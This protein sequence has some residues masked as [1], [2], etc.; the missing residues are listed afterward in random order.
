M[1]LRMTVATL[2]LLAIVGCQSAAP[3]IEPPI[4]F[5]QLAANVTPAENGF[6][7]LES[8][9]S[10]GR[11]ATTLAVAKFA[12]A[13]NT[14]ATLSLRNLPDAEQAYWADTFRG[15]KPV[16]DLVFLSPVTFPSSAVTL[17]EL[18]NEARSLGATVLLTYAPN[19]YGPNA[20]QVLGVL[21][22]TRSG[23]AIATLHAANVFLDSAGDETAVDALR[24]DQREQDAAYQS[25]RRFEAYARSCINNLIRLDRPLDSA[26]AA[27]TLHGQPLPIIPLDKP[28][29]SSA[30]K[31]PSEEPDSA[32]AATSEPEFPAPLPN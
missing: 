19:R 29:A 20:A 2:S 6:R 8:G 16:R 31:R 1:T 9:S 14:A 7:L 28:L 24:G 4:E 12:P 10:Q 23:C 17:T 25:A 21:Y 32:P 30:V 15:I 26:T 27:P 22:D 13:D 5:A 11:F 3:R 18:C